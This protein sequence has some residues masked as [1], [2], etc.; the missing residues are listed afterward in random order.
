MWPPDLPSSLVVELQRICETELG[1]GLTLA[2]AE[3]VG[4]RMLA[5]FALLFEV[6]ERQAVHRSSPRGLLTNTRTNE[7][8]SMP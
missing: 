6:H 8:L 1:Q 5:M 2:E 7:T 3:E 4:R